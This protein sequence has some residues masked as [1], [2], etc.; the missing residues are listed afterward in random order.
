MGQCSIENKLLS[1]LLQANT[2]RSFGANIYCV[3]VKDFD[4]RQV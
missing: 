4:E 2:A 1:V 3:G